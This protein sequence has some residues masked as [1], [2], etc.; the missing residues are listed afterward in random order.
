MS[1]ALERIR[2]R[3]ARQFGLRTTMRTDGG[4]LAPTVDARLRMTELTL[5]EYARRLE[6]DIGEQWALASA[7][8]NGWTWLFR[9]RDQLAALVDR[10]AA[11]ASVEPLSIWVAGC[12]TGEE[13]YGVAILCAERGLDVRIT[14]TDLARA[15][16]ETAARGIYD[17]STLRAIPREERA[18]WLEPLA[19]GSW[20]MRDALRRVVELRV[21]NLMDA[22]PALGR[23]DAVVCRNVLIHATEDG[24]LR[25]VRGLTQALVAGGELVLGASDLFQIP[26]APA[27]SEP[28]RPLERAHRSPA[29]AT[30]ERVDAVALVTMGNL[31]VDAHAFD[32]AEAAYR[33]AEMLD[34]CSAELHLAWGVFHR[35]RG[36]IERAA[37]ALRRAAFLDETLW[38]AWALLAGTLARLGAD[39]ESAV[40]LQQARRARHDRPALEWRS[41][42]GRLL[43]E[44]L[45]SSF[46]ATSARHALDGERA[47]DRGASSG[48]V[49]HEKRRAAA[50]RGG[51]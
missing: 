11:K 31:C 20:R 9:D 44:Q 28:R 17:E 29:V 10:L 23:F 4:A 12:S 38:P 48:R 46:D 26:L 6:L 43:L 37:A 15:R 8:S 33:R 16:I 51:E 36:D 50:L 25:M 49:E 32:R 1:D 14:A 40:A 34:P 3:I 41:H 13:A 18:R 42:T 47:P 19:P 24:A 2:E 22:P 5:E 7:L 27:P 39:R 35:K 21:H 45:A 30:A